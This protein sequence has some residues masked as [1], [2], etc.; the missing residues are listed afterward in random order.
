YLSSLLGNSCLRPGPK[1]VRA[2]T[3]CSGVARVFSVR[4]MVAMA[5][6]SWAAG[7]DLVFRVPGLPNTGL[8]EPAPDPGHPGPGRGQGPSLARGCRAGTDL[9][10]VTSEPTAAPLYGR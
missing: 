5:V 10:G 9:G 7:S 1:S 4:W 3:N 6:L 8:V 2:S